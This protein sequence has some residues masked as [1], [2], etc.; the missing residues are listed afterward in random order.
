ME[1][2]QMVRLSVLALAA[3]AL[4]SCSGASSPASSSTVSGNKC[5]Y[6]GFEMV[7]EIPY[8][9]FYDENDQLISFYSV[10]YSCDHDLAACF[11]KFTFDSTENFII[12]KGQRRVSIYSEFV[13]VWYTADFQYNNEKNQMPDT[14]TSKE[15][16]GYIE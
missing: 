15:P 6:D 8:G 2:R 3:I 13:L 10:S 7:E 11:V 12:S 9:S 16:Y 14:L 1:K 4:C 5:V